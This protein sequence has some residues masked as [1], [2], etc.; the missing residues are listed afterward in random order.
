MNRGSWMRTRSGGRFYPADPRPEDIKILDIASGLAKE[1]RYGGQLEP[2]YSVAEHSI[3]VAS[4]LPPEL[5][6]Q[7]L[8]HDAEEA[9]W[10]DMVRPARVLLPDYRAYAAKTWRAVADCF[11][12]P[13]ELHD[14]VHQADN[15]VLLAEKAQLFTEDTSEWRIKGVMAN[16]RI[17]CLDYREAEAE[18]LN[19]FHHLT[20]GIYK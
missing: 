6:L 18:F 12:I 16:V 5:K 3:L 7:G 19:Y 4:V 8:L 20:K 17:R 13:R 2:H 1:C 10:R 9:W 14:L 15:D 11:G